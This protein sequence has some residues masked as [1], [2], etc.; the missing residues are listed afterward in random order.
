MKTIG[1]ADFKQYRFLSAVTWSPD[2]SRAA[3][4]VKQAKPTDDGYESCIW[5]YENGCCRKLTS[6]GNESSFIWEDDTHLIFPSIRSEE[7]KKRIAEND[8]FTA[9]Y[10]LDICGG[11]AEKIFEVPLHVQSIE[12]FVNGTYY[13]LGTINAE[14]ADYYSMSQE[15]RA[16]IIA[17]RK[18][19]E[20]YIVAEEVPFY[21]NG[22]PNY[23]NLERIALFVYDPKT[24]S[25]LRKT[26]PM[27]RV[28]GAVAIGHKIYYCGYKF[29]KFTDERVGL[30]C[31]DLETDSVRTVIANTQ[32]LFH[33]IE[34][35]NGNLILLASDTV[36]YG[37]SENPFFYK[38][39]TDLGTMTPILKNE[40]SIGSSVGS[41]C[42]LG[43]G[44]RI[45][46]SGN[47]LY[48]PITR[49]GDC[50]FCQLNL[51]GTVKELI[52]E[53]G[54]ID[55]FDVNEQGNIIAVCM[56][57][58][59]LQELYTFTDDGKPIMKSSFN[60]DI[61][62]DKYI[63]TP[64]KMVVESKGLSVSGWVL[65]P[66][67]F[68][69]SQSY[70]AILDIHGGPK[71]SFGSTFFHEMQYWANEGWFVFYCNPFGSDGLGN[72]FADIRGKYG[73]TDFINIMDFTDE[74][75]AKYP[76]IDSKRIAVTGGSYGGF[77]T[78]WIIGH[79]DRFA[80][81]ATQRS[82]VDWLS[83][84]GV[85]DIG[86]LF[87]Q[88]QLAADY[89]TEPEVFWKA[90]PIAYARHIK[91]PTLILHSEQ[92]YRCP[93]HQA[94]ELYT[95]IAVRGVP[96][97]MVVFKRENHEMSRSGQPKH[98]QRRLEELTRWFTIYTKG[99]DE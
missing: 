13:I 85:S 31:Y 53:Q 9:F 91:T 52:K 30:Y 59:K 65:K 78:N 63:A 50:V 77:M 84:Y 90:S 5:L 64:E 69:E 83:S 56:Y 2:G 8:E 81:A 54:S 20:D 33:G 96:A 87:D 35:V 27:F 98:R 68:N 10:R 43:S 4:I 49:D 92:D 11:E 86:V 95:A 25:C 41:D 40:E 18:E 58:T 34:N 88:D 70:P 66:K 15:E 39:D 42:R 36:R 79:T 51:D 75:L 62:K 48:Y 23:T 72:D 37:L 55:S 93:V 6:M 82:V 73:T 24:K 97:R 94:L 57:Q 26:D 32:A 19:E 45:V 44:R 22:N 3:F 47:N 12:P 21:S 61:L 74:V 99:N 17:R 76:Q 67:D 89:Y 14:F 28:A 46:S 1:L 60:D 16:D 80:C 7:E 29:E 71:T 38:V